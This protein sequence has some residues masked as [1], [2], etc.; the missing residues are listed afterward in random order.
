MVATNAAI[1]DTK[2]ATIS[3]A[4]KVADTALSSN[5]TKLGSEIDLDSAET[6]GVLPDSKVADSLTINTSVAA[7]FTGGV[8]LTEKGNLAT[9]YALYLK[10]NTDTSPLGY[11]IQA[12]NAA[13]NSNLFAVDVTGAITTGTIGWGSVTSKPANLDIDSTNDLTTSTSWS[14]DLTGTGTSPEIAGGAIV[15]ADINADAGIVDTKL[16]TI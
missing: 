16:A 9:D 11:L 14:G 5:V 3:T 12:Q 7:I 6:S 15:N 1:V 10:R 4:G 2:L 13:S 8:S